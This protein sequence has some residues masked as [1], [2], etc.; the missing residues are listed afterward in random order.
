MCIATKSGFYWFLLSLNP[1]GHYTHSSE[2]VNVIYHKHT[3]RQFMLILTLMSQ[4]VV[5]IFIYVHLIHFQVHFSYIELMHERFIEFM[6][7]LCNIK[8]KE[9]AYYKHK[10]VYLLK[11]WSNLHMLRIIYTLIF[12]FEIYAE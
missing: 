9:N 10:L 8:Y 1:F 11:K 5:P 3:I 2:V 7:G 6:L 12:N 4:I